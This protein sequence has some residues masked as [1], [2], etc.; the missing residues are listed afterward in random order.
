MVEIQCEVS[1]LKVPVA[2]KGNWAKIALNPTANKFAA[3]KLCTT[4]FFFNCYT[5][6]KAYNILIH[7]PDK[8]TQL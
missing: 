8:V 2:N 3:K 5:P 1:G 7:P 6:S 4:F